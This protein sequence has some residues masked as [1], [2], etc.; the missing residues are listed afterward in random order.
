M[1][2]PVETMAIQAANT[3]RAL[4]ALGH[5]ELRD[6]GTAH[7]RQEEFP[8]VRQMAEDEDGPTIN[9]AE[10]AL[11]RRIGEQAKAAALYPAAS[12]KGA[13]FQAYIGAS[14]ASCISG[15]ISSN[16]ACPDDIAAMEAAEHE[17]ALLFSSTIAALEAEYGIDPDLEILRQW[18]WPCSTD[19][20]RLIAT[21]IEKAAA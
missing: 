9:W 2:C 15:H 19:R 4:K 16:T 12:I 3:L 20:A 5:D 13:L 11:F 14:I 21:I 17:A 18:F 7:W 10:K 6:A 8:L 1:T